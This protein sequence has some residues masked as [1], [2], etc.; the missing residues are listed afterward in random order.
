MKKK[1]LKDF[2]D[3]L[4]PRN[5][6]DLLTRYRLSAVNFYLRHHDVLRANRTIWNRHKG[7][8]CFIL[9]NGPSVKLQDISALKN[10]TVIAV[11]NGYLHPEYSEIKP[12]YHC[13]PQITYSEKMTSGLTMDWF[14]EIHNSIG[15]A[16][17]FLDQQ[18]WALVQENNL[19]IS[20]TVRYVCMGRR[21]FPD[22]GAI[23][24]LTG[25]IPR[26]QTV[27][28]MAIMIALY[29]GFTEIYLLG[30]D[31]DWFVKK[32]YKYFY[33]P[34]LLKGVDI[35]VRPDGTLETTLWDEIPAISK[36]WTQY[37]S[38]KKIAAASGAVIR[39][40]TYGGMLDE[41]ERVPLEIV[42]RH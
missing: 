25:I 12:K 22:S 40:A 15:K 1:Q 13:I 29:M 27:P 20:R 38:V 28:I 11:S 2:M 37:R 30:T 35:G 33:E 36:V 24:D 9:C 19:F 6:V 8:R 39:N 17:L 26:V 3:W 7:E 5:F 31:H 21:G 41:F 4:L 10:E 14:R 34:G 16:E 23:P 32:E 42:L 18:E